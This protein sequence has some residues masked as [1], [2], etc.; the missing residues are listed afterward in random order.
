MDLHRTENNRPDWENSSTELNVYQKIASKTR[1]IATPGNLV[2]TAGLGLVAYGSTK[3]GTDLVEGIG[4]VTAGRLADIA[5]GVLANKTDTKSPLGEKFDAVADKLAVGI[6]A[7][8]VIENNLIPLPITLGILAQN[9]LNAVLSSRGKLKNKGEM[10]SSKT[11]KLATT[12]QW[13]TMGLFGLSTYLEQKGLKT[14]DN[15]IKALG[16]ASLYPT[17]WLSTKAS[18][19]YYKD[20]K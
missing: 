11:G 9:G 13:I 3:L 5:D 15:I 10:H 7:V 2:T 17:I 8:G 19:G 4:F 6:V 18:V 12:F 1:G 14:S 20:F 16:D